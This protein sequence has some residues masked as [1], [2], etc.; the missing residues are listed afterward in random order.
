MTYGLDYYIS[1]NPFSIINSIILIIGVYKIGLVVQK[2]ILNNFFLNIKNNDIYYHSFLFG[3]YIVSYLLYT[4]T[5]LQ[6]ANLFTFKMIA[7]IIYFLG[8]FTIIKFLFDKKNINKFKIYN[9]F[10]SYILITLLCLVGMMLIS[11]SPITQADALDY[12]T[13]SSINILNLGAFDKE[14]LPM[15]SKLASIGELMM[16]LGF[17]IKLEQFGSLVQFSSIFSLIPLFLK[18]K[19]SI[20]Y[21]ILLTI[22]LS[23]ITIFFISSP[24]PQLVQCVATLLIFSFLIKDLVNYTQTQIKVIF[25]VIVFILAMNV[26]IKYS[27]IVSSSILYLYCIYLMYK[28]NFLKKAIFISLIIFSITI[29]P[30]WIHRHI[31]FDTSF[32][33]LLLSPLPLNIYGYQNLHNL[34]SP[35]KFNAMSLIIPKNLGELSTTYGPILFLIFFIKANYF[36]KYK[37]FYLMILIFGFIHYYFGSNLTR[38]FYEGYLWLMYILLKSDPIVNRY[39]IGYKSLLKIQ[40]FFGFFLV[41]MSAYFLFQGSLSSDL[42]DKTMNNHANGY[43]LAKWVNENVDEKDILLTTHRSYSLY[44][45]QTYPIM[46]TRQIDLKKQKK[47]YDNL[48]KFFKNKKN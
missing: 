16:T 48:Y 40:I 46:F 12:H 33:D 39:F 30:N 9:N 29:L 37:D 47:K 15:T 34:L 25:S 10:S 45:N 18:K 19:R 11:L 24:K 21:L 4:I 38:F 14:L 13:S 43:S 23:P 8:L 1:T 7:L 42:R 17:A 26:L 27:F 22:L 28:I 20:N 35:N 44:N 6:L 2:A 41:Y 31:Y 3:I 36:K 32:F 5:I